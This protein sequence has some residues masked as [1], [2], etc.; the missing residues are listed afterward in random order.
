LEPLPLTNPTPSGGVAG[1]YE[2][3]YNGFS[4]YRYITLGIP[5]GRK[6]V[7]DVIDTWAMTIETLPGNYSGRA[8]VELPVRPYMAVR[9]RVQQESL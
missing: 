7:I 8:R 9:V 4:Q 2:I 6:A 3:H 5:E 1:E